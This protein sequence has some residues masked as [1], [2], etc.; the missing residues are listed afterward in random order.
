MPQFLQIACLTVGV[1]L[2]VAAFLPARR[3]QS[4]L[5][6]KLGIDKIGSLEMDPTAFLLL[7][8]AVFAAVPLFFLW[9]GYESKLAEMSAIQNQVLELRAQLE[10]FKEYEMNIALDF[11]ENVN[12][13]A[14][15][16]EIWV[17]K[18]QE[19]APQLLSAAAEQHATEVL[20]VV[21]IKLCCVNPGDQVFF[22]THEFS[23]SKEKRHWKSQKLEIPKAN[24]TME[25]QN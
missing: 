12:L 16:T 6:V 5:P 2:M 7:L 19:V 13:A 20:N 3:S 14:L 10:A 22:V 4:R 15:K 25:I 11:H 23:G 17:R 1:A 24:L 9:Q 8:G 18:P 21:A